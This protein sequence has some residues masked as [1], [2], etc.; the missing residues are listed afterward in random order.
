MAQCCTKAGA[1]RASNQGQTCE[2]HLQQRANWP[3]TTGQSAGNAAIN[4]RI[5]HA[6]AI[7]LRKKAMILFAEMGWPEAA[8]LI[9]SIIALSVGAVAVAICQTRSRK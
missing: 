8:V 7:F 5:Q 2:R 3:G 1:I 6:R 4:Y 9:V